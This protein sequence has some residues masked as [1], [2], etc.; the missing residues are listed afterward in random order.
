MTGMDDFRKLGS[1]F[2]RV[3][4][5][6]GV[7]WNIDDT[8]DELF[9]VES[10]QLELSVKD[11]TRFHVI[12]TLLH[13]TMVGE[14]EVFS[15]QTRACK[16]VAT[17]ECVLWRMSREKFEEMQLGEPVLALSFVQMALKFISTRYRNDRFNYR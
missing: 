13:A 2:T 16:L 4:I 1:Y 7:L 17:G 5:G 3:E 6:R 11:K 10:G 8:A 9:I 12:E 15:G 14:L